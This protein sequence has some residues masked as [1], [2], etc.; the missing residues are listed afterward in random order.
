[1]RA[2]N[3]SVELSKVRRTFGPFFGIFEQLFPHFHTKRFEFVDLSQSKRQMA[4]ITSEE[5]FSNLLKLACAFHIVACDK[6]MTECPM[7]E[8]AHSMLSFE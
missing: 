1:M 3:S 8:W 6:N 5:K 7:I 2:Q 4:F